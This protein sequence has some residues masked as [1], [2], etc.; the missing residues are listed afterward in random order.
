MRLMVVAMV[1][2]A[3]AAAVTVEMH[4]VLS[5][6]RIYVRLFPIR[7]H[8]VLELLFSLLTDEDEAQGDL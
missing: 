3:A 8:V 7:S 6:L 1:L 5:A 4:T 2:L